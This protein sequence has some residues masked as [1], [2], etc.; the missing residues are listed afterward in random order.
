MPT[1]NVTDAR[2]QD[3]DRQF[4]QFLTDTGERNGSVDMAVDGS[5]I[6]QHFWITT[7]DTDQLLL[8]AVTITVAAK[9]LQADRYGDLSLINGMNVVV[10]SGHD[11][12]NVHL[13]LTEQVPILTLADWGQYGGTSNVTYSGT[14]IDYWQVEIPFVSPFIM[15]PGHGD[16]FGIIINDDLSTLDIHHMFVRGWKLDPQA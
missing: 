11:L 3:Q 16:A 5:I 12:N 7:D 6:P 2:H 9:K 15:H 14:D 4:Y 10:S 1:V 8:D 13:I